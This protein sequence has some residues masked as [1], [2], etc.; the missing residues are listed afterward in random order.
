MRIRFFLSA[1]ALLAST[2]LAVEIVSPAPEGGE[3]PDLPVE[4][5]VLAVTTSFLD[6]NPFGH[7]VNGENNKLL[8]TIE[9]R[10]GKNVTLLSVAGEF[11]NPGTEQLIK[12]ANNLTYG[13]YLPALGRIQ[14]PYNFYS[15]FKTGDIKLSIWLEH[16]IDGERKKV[17]AF[18][19]IVTVVE[20]ELSIFD[21]KLLST[22]AIVLT[23]LSGLGY[24]TYLS[25]VPQPKQKKK[26]PATAPASTV[27]VTGAGG[28][29]EEWIPENHLR[30][31]KA[32]KVGGVVS[33][34]DEKSGLS[35]GE[36]SGAE[37][38]RHGNRLRK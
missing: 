23:I 20:P 18:D 8:L 14:L 17:S 26:L 16:L 36:A 12:A 30:K 22:Y 25:F 7:V 27:T 32:R 28:Y 35:G 10:T 15:E 5:P 19:S 2:V 4:D 9:N 29:Q 31:S 11:L 13:I 38:K 6:N 3:F 21:F 24:A 1:I 37:G 34:G 33:S